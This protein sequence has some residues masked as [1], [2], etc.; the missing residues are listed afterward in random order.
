MSAYGVIVVWLIIFIWIIGGSRIMSGS[1]EPTL[2][3]GDTIII[4]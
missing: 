3:T 2:M 4:N 1:M